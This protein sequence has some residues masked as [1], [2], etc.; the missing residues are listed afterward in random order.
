MSRALSAARGDVTSS[1]GTS[2]TVD[3]GGGLGAVSTLLARG[4]Q[5][6]L[7]DDSAGRVARIFCVCCT[8]AEYC[9]VSVQEMADSLKSKVAARIS[10]QVISRRA[11]QF[12]CV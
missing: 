4:K 5:G 6:A 11:V 8:T 12:L 3:G 9:G 7:V 2:S 10:D 1:A